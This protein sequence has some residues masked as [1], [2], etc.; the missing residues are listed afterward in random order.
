[1]L[2][3]FTFSL[4]ELATSI[5]FIIITFLFC[6]AMLLLISVTHRTARAVSLGRFLFNKGGKIAW[7]EVPKYIVYC[8]KATKYD[9]KKTWDDG[10]YWEGV[11]KWGFLDKKSG[12][13]INSGYS[14]YK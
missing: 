9:V 13:Y 11:G 12:D 14:K 7:W 2:D 4:I 1:M 6:W 5:R 8:Y 10:S 3:L